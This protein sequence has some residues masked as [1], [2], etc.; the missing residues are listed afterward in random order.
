[1]NAV[2]KSQANTFIHFQ[3]DTRHWSTNTP[4]LKR[5]SQEL[6]GFHS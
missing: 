3:V 1:M 5:I 2:R 4:L 6:T